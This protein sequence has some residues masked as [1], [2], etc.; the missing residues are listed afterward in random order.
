MMSLAAW[1][2]TTCGI[3]FGGVGL[4]EGDVG[5]LVVLAMTGV[6]SRGWMTAVSVMLAS[7]VRWVLLG[8]FAVW[9]SGVCVA[10]AAP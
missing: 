2:L 8:L 1:L 4:R 7:D 10:V 6:A 3:A 5:S 9:A